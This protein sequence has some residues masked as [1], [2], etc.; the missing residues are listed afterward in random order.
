MF[1]QLTKKLGHTIMCIRRCI[2]V[3]TN[4][5]LDDNLMKAAMEA[6]GLKTKKEVVEKALIEFVERHTRKNLKDLMGKIQFADGYDYKA[7]REGRK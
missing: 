2:A 6:S 3:R 4:I 5:V 1:Y 7:L